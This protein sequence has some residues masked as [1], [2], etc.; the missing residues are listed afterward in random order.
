MLRI[1]GEIFFQMAR[2]Q[3]HFDR[4]TQCSD[5]PAAFNTSDS[6]ILKEPVSYKLLTLKLTKQKFF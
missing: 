2:L 6:H 3:L 5:M 1:M 4:A